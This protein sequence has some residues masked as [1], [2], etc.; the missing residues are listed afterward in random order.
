MSAIEGKADMGAP[1]FLRPK[2]AATMPW[3]EAA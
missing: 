1:H 3:L 2:L